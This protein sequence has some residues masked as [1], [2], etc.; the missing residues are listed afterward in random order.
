[1]TPFKFLV[2]KPIVVSRRW[3]GRFGNIQPGQLVWIYQPVGVIFYR[4]FTRQENGTLEEEI[5][6]TT[7]QSYSRYMRSYNEFMEMHS[8]EVIFAYEFIDNANI[9][10]MIHYNQDNFDDMPRNIPLIFRGIIRSHEVF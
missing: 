1:M 7:I 10:N 3:C 4:E 2:N 8:D 9:S 6:T 5:K